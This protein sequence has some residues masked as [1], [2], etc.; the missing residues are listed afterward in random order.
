MTSREWKAMRDRLLKMAN[1]IV[2]CARCGGWT[3]HTAPGQHQKP[4]ALLMP[5][6]GRGA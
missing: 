1:L 4:R 3:V 5:G 6:E 2:F